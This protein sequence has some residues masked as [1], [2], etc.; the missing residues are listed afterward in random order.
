MTVSSDHCNECSGSIN[1]EFP[2]QLRD[3]QLLKQDVGLAFPFLILCMA[4]QP[5]VGL[6]P[7]FQFLNLT[8]SW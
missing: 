4:Q 7:L 5:F 3:Y 6:W 8:H 2:E 1:V